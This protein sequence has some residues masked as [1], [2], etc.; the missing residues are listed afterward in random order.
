MPMKQ[1]E[2]RGY[3]TPKLWQNSRESY[4]ICFKN[5]VAHTCQILTM[6][7]H[8]QILFHCSSNDIRSKHPFTSFFLM[9][10]RRAQQTKNVFAAVYSTEITV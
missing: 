1:Y 8:Y 6:C 2:N 9:F 10:T 7:A 5:E 3:M 4:H